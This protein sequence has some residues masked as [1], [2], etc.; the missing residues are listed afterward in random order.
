VDEGLI[1]WLIIFAVAILQGIGQRKK[2]PGQRPGQPGGRR[3]PRQSSPD[4]RDGAVT[5]ADRTATSS[6]RRQAGGGA[7]GSEGLI[8]ADVWEEILGLARGQPPGKRQGPPEPEERAAEEVEGIE[9]GRS[10]DDEALEPSATPAPRPRPA[11]SPRPAPAPSPR[12]TPA[13]SARPGPSP[14]RTPSS[15]RTAPLR[16]GPV[17]EPVASP[18]FR[19]GLATGGDSELRDELF[20]S[21]APEDLRKAIILR[22]VLGPPLALKE[23]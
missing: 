13:P 3:V 17:S 22:E 7:E 21:G 23:E 8:P 14:G 19:P 6:P 1:F 9:E 15:A 20:G 4:S 16:P 2:K 10:Y 12:P 5:R 11:P 18:I